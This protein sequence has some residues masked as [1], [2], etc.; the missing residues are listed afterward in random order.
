MVF[1][2]AFDVSKAALFEFGVPFPL[3]LDKSLGGDSTQGSGL[4]AQWLALTA[5]SAAG[6]PG[7]VS[8]VIPS[9]FSW[10][11]RR[12]WISLLAS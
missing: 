12:A 4:K 8:S 10:D 11:W 6:S 2:G 7:S 3:E 5:E 9:G 1:G